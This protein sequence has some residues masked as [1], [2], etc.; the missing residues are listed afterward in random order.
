MRIRLKM[1]SLQ[2]NRCS[3]H[4]SLPSPQILRQVARIIYGYK[5]KKFKAETYGCETRRW[6]LLMDIAL[7]L[8]RLAGQ[9]GALAI[10][11]PVL[12][13]EFTSEFVG[14]A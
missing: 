9:L 7:P 4:S 10:A 14:V 5:C 1:L 12:T 11:L 2:D 8:E 3:G 13:F 6:R